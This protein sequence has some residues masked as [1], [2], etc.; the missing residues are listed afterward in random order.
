M[1]GRFEHGHILL[2]HALDGQPWRYEQIRGWE[3]EDSV[4]LDFIMN[5]AGDRFSKPGY[6][7]RLSE[8]PG[9]DLYKGDLRLVYPL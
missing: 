3:P 9:V 2:P 7:E 8:I 1:A 4:S 6:R 5:I